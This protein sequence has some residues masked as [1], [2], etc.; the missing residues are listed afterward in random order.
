MRRG[1]VNFISVAMALLLL[2]QGFLWGNLENILRELI[3]FLTGSVEKVGVVALLNRAGISGIFGILG[4]DF[5]CSSLAFYFACYCL[6][7]PQGFGSAADIIRDYGGLL[8]CIFV[9]LSMAIGE[10]AVFRWFP[11]WLLPKIYFLSGK[12]AFYVLAA[13]SCVIFAWFHSPGESRYLLIVLPQFLGGVLYSFVF[14]KYGFWITALMHFLFNLI[15]V[16]SAVAT[17][18]S[19]N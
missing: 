17:G 7:I 12:T 1:A 8:K 9:L 2:F 3:L 5:I 11:L 19:R 16:I 18:K 4:I 10:E 6:K 15:A 14:V 13:A